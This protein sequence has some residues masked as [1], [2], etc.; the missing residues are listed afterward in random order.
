MALL[1]LMQTQVDAIHARREPDYALMLDI[2]TYLREYT[3]HSHHPREDVAFERLARYCP[4]L[5]L[6]LARL[7]QEHRVIAHTGAVLAAQITAVL[8]GEIVPREEIEAAAS[9]F[10]VYYRHHLDT[11]DDSVLAQAARHLTAD[12]WNAVRC[13]V[14]PLADP[15][16]GE[17]PQERF[18]RL[19]REL[20][21]RRAA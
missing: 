2:L 15:L 4:E 16:F 1:R 13:A 20:L 17:A 14:T 11:E 9:T 6:V 3:D 8:Q 10:L 7:Q 5:E 18:K 19:R 21:E 12:D